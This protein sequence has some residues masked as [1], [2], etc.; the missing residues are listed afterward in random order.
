MFIAA[1]LLTIK[2]HGNDPGSTKESGSPLKMGDQNVS[3]TIH[4][5]SLVMIIMI[6]GFCVIV[7]TY[8]PT[9]PHPHRAANRPTN[10]TNAIKNNGWPGFVT[11]YRTCHVWW[12]YVQ[13]FFVIVLTYTPAHP[14]PH[15]AANR[16]IVYNRKLSYRLETGHQQCI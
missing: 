3:C 12:W 16:P 13:C 14:H 10:P 9:H 15:T 11:Y 1:Y 7:L 8:R 4:L 6:S 5:P 2:N